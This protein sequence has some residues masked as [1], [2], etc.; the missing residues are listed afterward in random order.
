M[1]GAVVCWIL[2]PW[3]QYL[4]KH[5]YLSVLRTS[6]H[7]V[8]AATMPRLYKQPIVVSSALQIAAQGAAQCHN[9]C[10]SHQPISAANRDGDSQNRASAV[11]CG[12]TSLQSTPK[13]ASYSQAPA[14]A[15]T[16]PESAV[17]HSFLSLLS[18]LVANSPTECTT[19]RF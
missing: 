18:A 15:V 17:G 3:V 5:S 4:P 2:L 7:H 8:I 10:F 14:Q 12:F 9:C 11:V 6:T 1:A 19:C 16:I 13:H